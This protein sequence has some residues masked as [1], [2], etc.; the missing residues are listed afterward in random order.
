[1]T[2]ESFY[3]DNG[4]CDMSDHGACGHFGWCDVCPEKPRK[5]GVY[6][7]GVL[8]ATVDPSGTIHYGTDQ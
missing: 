8:S 5:P 4:V 6:N 7:V 2:D 3:P 1:V